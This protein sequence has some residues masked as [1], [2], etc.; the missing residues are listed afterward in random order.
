MR[1][2]WSKCICTKMSEP[3]RKPTGNRILDAL[4]AREFVRLSRYIALKRFASGSVLYHLGDSIDFVHFP[5]S[6]VFSANIVLSDGSCLETGTIGNEGFFGLSGL[7]GNGF[8]HNQVTIYLGGDGLSLP[9]P[10]F[11]EE[12]DRSGSL[13]D[14]CVKLSQ[15]VVA[16]VSQTAACN[17]RHDLRSRCARWLLAMQDKVGTQNFPVIQEVLAALLGVQRPAI[18]RVA[19]SLRREGLIQYRRGLVEIR[20]RPRLAGAACE[21]YRVMRDLRDGF[22]NPRVLQGARQ[23]GDPRG[24]V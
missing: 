5:V 12:L 17:A 15:L 8:A 13:R 21:C 14:L 23:F 11:R 22:L 1:S 10:V 24:Q 20:D 19:Q 9:T 6:A 16:E 18:T 7:F 3:Q 2:N 4:P